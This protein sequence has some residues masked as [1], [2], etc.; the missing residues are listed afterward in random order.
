MHGLIKQLRDRWFLI[1]LGLML[2]IGFRFCDPLAG[3][4]R[5]SLLQNGVVLAVMFLMA[6]PLSFRAFVQSIRRPVPAMLA[7]GMNS[8]VTPLLAWGAAILLAMMA[9]DAV[10]GK[11]L[12]MGLLV[13]GATPCT[14]ASAAVW[15]RRAGG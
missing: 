14:L 9:R 3:L 6:L 12:A 5:S 1:G 2:V 8:G 11:E 10:V 15:T 4:T 7:V 13:A